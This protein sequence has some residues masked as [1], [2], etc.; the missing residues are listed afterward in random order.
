MSAVTW[1]YGYRYPAS[2]SISGGRFGTSALEY[3]KFR[4]HYPS[5][6]FDKFEALGPVHVL[7][8]G[9]GTGRVALPLIDRGMNVLARLG[10]GLEPDARMADV[11]RSRGVPV[12]IGTFERW[13]DAGRR[14]DLITCGAAWHWIEPEEGADKAAHI[15]RSGGTLARFINFRL[16]DDH[17]LASFDAV[18]SSYAPEVTTDGR[19]PSYL[20]ADDPVSTSTSS[21]G[22]RS[23]VLRSIREFSTDE[24]LGMIAT[25]S[26]HIALGSERLGALLMVLRD[27]TDNDFDGRLRVT[28]CTHVVLPRAFEEPVALVLYLHF[29]SVLT[30]LDSPAMAWAA[31]LLLLTCAYCSVGRV[32]SP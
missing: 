1:H 26:D 2:R 9:C 22:T 21:S 18:Y 23:H 7:D 17:A 14:F 8:I 31:E 15:L 29:E 20:D 32:D 24:W 16:L 27:L 3:D 30:S 11:A 19:P 28:S 12:E 13:D 6:L 4:P 25:L 5:E 10:L